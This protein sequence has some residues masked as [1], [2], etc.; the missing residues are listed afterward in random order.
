MSK[1]VSVWRCCRVCPGDCFGDDLRLSLSHDA[2][3]FQACVPAAAKAC[4]IGMRS[5]H[6]DLTVLLHEKKTHREAVLGFGVQPTYHR[7]RGPSAG[8]ALYAG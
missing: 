7:E 5:T 8:G 2:F 3:L 6:A 4:S 1:E